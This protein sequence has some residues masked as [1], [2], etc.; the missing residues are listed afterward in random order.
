MLLQIYEVLVVKARRGVEVL[1]WRCD[2]VT[3]R[4]QQQIA[5][6]GGDE[7][8]DDQDNGDDLRAICLVRT[9][10]DDV[11]DAWMDVCC[12]IAG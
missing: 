4:R 12:V 11:C 9:I 5:T 6:G 8:C 10:A 7:V 1:K 3:R 2:D